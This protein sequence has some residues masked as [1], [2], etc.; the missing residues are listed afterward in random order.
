MYQLPKAEL[1][2][3]PYRVFQEIPAMKS[4]SG[5]GPCLDVKKLRMLEEIQHVSHTHLRTQACSGH[6]VLK[7]YLLH[8]RCTVEFCVGCFL[9]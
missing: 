7:M 1:F 2:L 4:E 8:V 6:A 3:S 5:D 9:K